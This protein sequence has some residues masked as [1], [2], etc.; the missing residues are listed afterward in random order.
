MKVKQKVSAFIMASLLTLSATTQAFA[1]M[2][3]N[4]VELAKEA[5]KAVVNISTETT[6]NSSNRGR[7]M[8]PDEMFRSLPKEFGDLFRQ[9]ENNLAPRERKQSSLGSG[10]IISSDGY[11]VTNNHVV[12]GADKVSINLQGKTGKSE[13][14]EA[15]VIGTDAETDLALLKVETKEKLPTLKFGDSSDSEVGEWVLAIG[16]PFGL[17]HTVTAGI[18]SAKG[19]DIH[20]GPFDNFIQTD[21]SINPGNSGGPLINMDGEVIGINTAIIAS[22]QG[23]GFAIPSSQA[24]DIV[25]ALKKGEKVSRGWIGVGINDIDENTAK[26]L[27]LKNTNGALIVS[28]MK[29][30]PADKAGMKAG[31]V[32][33]QVADKKVN[34]SSELLKAIA[35]H[36][37]GEKIEVLV[38]RNGD[39]KKLN[40]VLGDRSS[41]SASKDPKNSKPETV[42]GLTLRPLQNAEKQSLEVENGL[43]VTAISNDSVAAEF[44]VRRNDVIIA[45]NLHPVASASELEKLINTEAKKRGAVLLQIMRKGQELFIS[46]PIKK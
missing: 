17:G 36:A 19:R 20:S 26:A 25:E 6:I 14:L 11:I 40:I 31:D 45:A 27:Q 39:T 9:F 38:I 42:L 1:A 35:S 3:G 21:A 43:L 28:V 44:G 8:F 34:N 16:N 37:P 24:S 22:G 12:E 33:V 2:P 23:I 15:K 7:N 41:Q 4:F 5:G 10:F 30:E 18:V 29:N 13:S 46:V 32:V